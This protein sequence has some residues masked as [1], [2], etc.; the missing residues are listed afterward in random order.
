L[1][2][3]I[4]DASSPSVITAYEGRIGKLE[5]ERLLLRERAAKTLPPKGRFEEFIEQSLAFLAKP[6]NIYENCSL[7]LKQT[8]LR[9]SIY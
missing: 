8:V 1:L 9:L 6:W 5:R 7:L 2:D 4:V 3:R